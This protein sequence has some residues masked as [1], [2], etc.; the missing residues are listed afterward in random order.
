MCCF[1][2]W[3]R[4]IVKGINLNNRVEVAS[5][6]HQIFILDELHKPK[7][8]PE[9]EW[10]FHVPFKDRAAPGRMPNCVFEHVLKWTVLLFIEFKK[11][12]LQFSIIMWQPCCDH[13]TKHTLSDMHVQFCQRTLRRWSWWIVGVKKKTC[14]GK[15]DNMRAPWLTVYHWDNMM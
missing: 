8:P 5:I 2:Q 12:F 3:D 14:T 9:V 4:E 10:T 13:M 1:T 6:P 11:F 15:F 7:Q